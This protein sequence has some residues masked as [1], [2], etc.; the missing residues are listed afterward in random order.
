M[1]VSTTAVALRKLFAIRR[2]GRWYVPGVAVLTSVATVAALLSVIPGPVSTV[3][4]WTLTSDAS[5]IAE[6]GGVAQPVVGFLQFGLV[7]IY[8]PVLSLLLVGGGEAAAV[9]LGRFR[10]SAP[11]V[12]GVGAGV[13]PI[14]VTG[15]GCG[16]GTAGASTTL[17]EQALGAGLL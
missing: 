5:P 2:L 3:T 1:N 4:G 8:V 15:C 7:R 6:A 14:V 12:V 17:L 16:Y 9:L 13:Q 10:I 11:F